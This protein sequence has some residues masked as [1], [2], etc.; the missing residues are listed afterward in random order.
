MPMRFEREAGDDPTRHNRRQTSRRVTELFRTTD[1]L[2]PF[3]PDFSKTRP[4]SWFISSKQRVFRWR[5][6]AR[7]GDQIPPLRAAGASQSRQS[8]WLIGLQNTD[9]AWLRRG[10]ESFRRDVVRLG[11]SRRKFLVARLA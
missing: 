2:P 6:R 5:N 7:D 3:C 9:L 4:S 8:E 1:F 10:T 11:R